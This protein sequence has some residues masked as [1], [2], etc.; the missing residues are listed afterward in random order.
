MKRFG[1]I[2][3]LLLTVSLGIVVPAKAQEDLALDLLA[4]GL[5]DLVAIVHAGD[6]RLFLCDKTGI[7]RIWDGTQVLEEPF[8]D[9]SELV[10]FSLQEGLLS[11]VFHPEYANNGFFYVYYSDTKTDPILARY[12]VMAENPNRADPASGVTLLDIP[13]FGGHYGGSLNFGPDGYLYFGIGD[14][15]EQE[16]PECRAQNMA[17]LQGKILRI[18]VDQ[19]IDQPPYHGTPA[20][21][22][23]VGNPLIPDEIWAIGLRNPWRL[24]FDRF[25]GDLLIADVGQHTREEVSFQPANSTGGENYGWNIMEATLCH[26]PDPINANCPPSTLS[27]FDQTYVEPIIEYEHIDGGDCAITG[28][29]VYRG[30]RHASLRGQY[31]YGDWCTGHLWA[32]S[33]ADDIWTPQLLSLSLQ[34]ITT[35]GEDSQGEIYLTNGEALYQLTS[36]GLFADGFESGETS[37][38]S[39]ALP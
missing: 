22:P 35:W 13:H 37:A 12:E 38:W 16:D 31:L 21:N 5:T 1:V 9:I 7:I 27:C 29:Y 6:Q 25:T 23:F 28:G 4:A 30:S 17:L 36:S 11:L 33:R 20:D 14:G 26:D 34:R 32:A 3:Y 19:S 15:G 2:L 10:S 8:L 39:D 18:D 24:T